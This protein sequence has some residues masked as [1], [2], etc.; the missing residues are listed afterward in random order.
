MRWDGIADDACSVART[1]AVVGDRWTLLIVR[2]CFLGVRRFEEFQTRLGLSKAT[3]VDRLHRLVDAGVLVTVAYSRRPPRAEYRLTARGHDLYPVLMA[4]VDWGNRHAAGEAGP[5]LLHTHGACGHD[6]APVTT[7]SHCGE[8]VCARDVTVR[9]APGFA[10]PRS[11][12]A[13]G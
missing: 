10:D 5:P 2:D 6:F 7:C 9:A 4:L 8:R 3:L 11:R 1:L 13:T 12:S